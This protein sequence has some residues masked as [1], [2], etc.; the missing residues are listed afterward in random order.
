MIVSKMAAAMGFNSTYIKKLAKE[1]RAGKMPGKN[2]HQIKGKF[3]KLDDFDL[4][5]IR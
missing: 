2:H 5:V 4:G 1:G 3:G